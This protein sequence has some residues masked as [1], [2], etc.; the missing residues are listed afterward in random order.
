MANNVMNSIDTV[1]LYPVPPQAKL[2]GLLL[3]T[4][5][6]L[7]AGC[8]DEDPPFAKEE[9][10]LRAEVLTE[11]AAN[12]YQVMLSWNIKAIA[13][14]AVLKRTVPGQSVTQLGRVDNTEHFLDTEV[15]AGKTYRYALAVEGTELDGTNISIPKDLEI[16]GKQGLPRLEGINRIFLRNAQIGTAGADVTL[17]ANEIISEESVIETFP[18]G[19]KAPTGLNGRPGG[20]ITIRAKSARGRLRIISRGE[21]GG[22]GADRGNGHDGSIG[23]QGSPG[24]WAINPV[25]THYL[26][27]S[28]GAALVRHIEHFHSGPDDY[29]W[30]TNIGGYKVPGSVLAFICKTIPGN[31]GTGGRGEDGKDGG[32]GG[33]GGDTARVIVQI[34]DATQFKLEVS[35]VAGA[36]GLGGR[37]GKG[38]KPGPGGPPGPQDQGHIC[39]PAHEGPPGLGGTDGRQGRPGKNGSELQVSRS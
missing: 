31:G 36:G 21:D 7:A 19:Q 11:T 3:L 6:F 16:V 35:A 1:A 32:P 26:G 2:I 12:R 29:I 4:L 33:N 20:E 10:R 34:T 23:A 8:A 37:G 25:Y 9:P 24:E 28:S 38:G 13:P 27:A 5:L 14:G 15:D 39:D 30:K 18:E 17:D 22:D